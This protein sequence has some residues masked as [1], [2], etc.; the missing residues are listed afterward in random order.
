MPAESTQRLHRAQAAAPSSS[1]GPE[2]SPPATNTIS[3]APRVGHKKSRKGCAQCKKRHVKCNEEAP[4]SNCV[5]HKVACSLAGGPHVTREDA[6][7]RPPSVTSSSSRSHS[8]S[9]KPGDSSRSTS[10]FHAPYAAITGSIDR[11]MSEADMTGARALDVELMHHYMLH[12]KYILFQSPDAVDILRVWQEETPR[13]AFR[14]EYVLHAMLGFT[15]LHKA[16]LEPE[17]L[18]KLQTFAVD[19]F[20]KAFRLYRED[21]SPFGV[22]NAEARF[23]FS[24]LATFFSFAIPPSA[25]PIDAMAE[26]LLLIRGVEIIVSSTW[27]WVSQG[28][29]API[30]ARNIKD[31]ITA[32]PD[33]YHSLEG[34]DMGLGHLDYMIGVEAMLPEDRRVCV[35]VTTEL[36]RL[37]D[38]VFRS[39]GAG[40]IAYILCFPTQDSPAFASLIKRRVPQA[41]VILAHYCVV[42]DVL[43]T[44]WWMHGWPARVM[45]DIVS[46][47]PAQWTQW[48]DWAVQSILIKPHCPISSDGLL[49]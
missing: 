13:I 1:V 34:I 15:A 4:C 17:R 46:S 33:A 49:I 28:P 20:D 44:R 22:D 30:F 25:L 16:H 40:S 31:G 14:H 37:Y 18:P 42:L 43:N 47:L 29:Y 21:S 36:K 38:G 3:R 24:W 10:P 48:I 7:P 5:R 9:H 19:H 45:T 41:L 32:P 12:T 8:T 39:P 35:A 27:Q 11:S 2:S 6:K 23:V 26:L